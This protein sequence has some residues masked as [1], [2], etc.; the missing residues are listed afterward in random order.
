M[1]GD[2]DD[3]TTNVWECFTRNRYDSGSNKDGVLVR[4][5]I[6]CSV[7]TKALSKTGGYATFGFAEL[8]TSGLQGAVHFDALYATSHSACTM[9][10]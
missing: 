5:P 9:A 2:T 1:L 8:F 7:E 6:K 4:K 3:W 10:T